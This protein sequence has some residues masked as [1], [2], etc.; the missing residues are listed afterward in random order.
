MS[1][2]DALKLLQKNYNSHPLVTQYAVRV[3]RNFLPETIIYYIPQLIQALRYDRT[4]IF[5]NFSL[6]FLIHFTGLVFDYLTTA[7][8]QSELLAHQLIW[9]TQTYTEVVEVKSTNFLRNFHEISLKSH[10]NLMS[11]PQSWEWLQ[12]N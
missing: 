2:P 11:R 9:N 10:L 6:N 1:P 3:L 5:S 12:Q 4:G 7:A 8:K